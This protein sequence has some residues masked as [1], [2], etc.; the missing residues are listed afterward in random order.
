MTRRVLRMMASWTALSLTGCAPVTY[1]GSDPGEGTPASITVGPGGG[2]SGR[3][4]AA[5]DRTAVPTVGAPESMEMPEIQDYTL[6][7]GLRVVL[8]ERHALPLVSLEL[9][10]RGGASAHDPGLAGLASLTADMLDEGTTTR[11][12]LQIADAVDLLG[13]SLSSTAGYD[14]SQLRLS[15]L[16]GH[17]GAA[18]DIL[19]DVVVNPTFPEAEL[20]RLRKERLARVIQRSDVPAALADDAFAEVLYGDQHPYGVSLL[21][22][23]ESLESLTRD[24]VV[25]FHRARYAPGQGALIVAGDVTRE[26]LD[27]MLTGALSGWTGRGEDP[28]TTP[29]PVA[30]VQRTIYLV[31]KPGATQ[32][33]VRVGRVAVDRRTAAYYPLAVANTV[34]GGSF[35]SRLNSTLREEKGYTYGAGSYFD[36]RRLPGPFQAAAAVATPV[37]DSAVVE[38]VREID[39]M[40]EEAVPAPELE[41][42]RNYLALRLPQ[43]FESLDD[44]VR[45]L[46]EL[47]LYGIPLDFYGGYVTA[48]E[49]VDARATLEVASEYLRT[50]GM[51]IVIA[52][53]RASIEEPLRALG[54]GPVVVLEPGTSSRA[55]S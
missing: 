35:T 29:R 51:A 17:L 49:A 25:A 20:E 18:L 2:P 13:A 46:S 48:V 52:G 30:A 32:S 12:A 8:V 41:R 19:A 6:D 24:E 54:L 28:P 1:T 16:R 53:D 3:S 34:L 42:A 50:S 26:A 21:G 38:F 10:L 47:V 43:R 23:K 39:R 15:V 45:R 36:M 14:A 33:E 55:G 4:G 9:Q 37:T 7:N 5:I 22:T 27:S 11:S 31:D 40:H 44:V